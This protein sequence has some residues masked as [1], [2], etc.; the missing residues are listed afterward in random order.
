M[1]TLK[2]QH[3]LV[4]GY[5]QLGYVEKYERLIFDEASKLEQ[6]IQSLVNELKERIFPFIHFDPNAQNRQVLEKEIKRFL[7]FVYR[8]K[9]A[10]SI[11][12]AVNN[13]RAYSQEF[14]QE[15]DYSLQESDRRF[16]KNVDDLIS[17]CEQVLNAVNDNKEWVT[18]F[19]SQGDLDSFVELVRDSQE[20]KVEPEMVRQKS[21]ALSTSIEQGLYNNIEETYGKIVR[22]YKLR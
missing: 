6:S 20:G 10:T 3:N 7:Q 19:P 17:Q 15:L 9:T 18:P 5:K 21:K 22:E 4:H 13:L 8:D 14:S 2:C 11:R 12:N 16:L 1:V